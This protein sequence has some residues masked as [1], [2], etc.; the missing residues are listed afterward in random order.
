MKNAFKKTVYYI[1]AIL[2]IPGRL[3]ET[4]DNFFVVPISQRDLDQ[5]AYLERVRSGK[6]KDKVV[7][8]I[9]DKRKDFLSLDPVFVPG[10]V[11]IG[12]MGS[13]KSVAMRFTVY[14]HMATN[15]ENTLYILID[16][17]KGMTDYKRVFEYERNVVKA[18][19]S[20]DKFI[21]IMDMLTEEMNLRKAEFAKVGAE[22]IYAYESMMRKADPDFVGVARIMLVFEEFHSLSGSKVINFPMNIDRP[23]T[24]AFQFK[25]M[26]R[27]ARSLGVN[28]VIATQRA[29]SEDI[30]T[31]LK[32][33]LGTMMAFRV[34]N[35]GDAAIA[36]L[37]AAADIRN[38]QKGRCAYE[39]GF[40]QFPFMHDAFADALL[41]ENVKPL[42]A[43]LFGK[44]VDDYHLATSGEGTEGF[45]WVKPLSALLEAK[46]QFEPRNIAKR[47]LREFEFTFEEQGND[48]LIAN[49]IAER[50]GERYAVVVVADRDDAS[51]KAISYLKAALTQL[52]CTKVLGICLENA[53][54]LQSVCNETSGLIIEKEDLKQFAKLRDNRH[55]FSDADYSAQFNQFS[56][57]R[58][59]Q[60]KKDPSKIET[61][62]D[63]D[64]DDDFMKAAV[65]RRQG[66]PEPFSKKIRG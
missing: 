31:S 52:R 61:D 29:T 66:E 1:K 57:S 9:S 37:P 19:L 36:N 16:P 53:S 8:G 41:K 10:Q 43:K 30:P 11:A 5:N 56:L 64:I 26:M 18:L 45:V 39:E 55:K 47:I 23:G 3:I 22:H 14:T 2:S 54:A 63:D 50:D 17:E 15:S 48:A 13:G 60:N 44:Q 4:I 7:L 65:R 62:D 32:P 27:V 35:Q 51:P 42:K 49:L 12:G 33:G 21:P 6:W 59:F 58:S 46:S 40:M 20:A 34:N 38:N 24:A 28:V 25:N